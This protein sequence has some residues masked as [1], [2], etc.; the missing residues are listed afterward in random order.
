MGVAFS[1][2]VANR[3]L[4]DEIEMVES[5]ILPLMRVAID[6]G[7]GMLSRDVIELAIQDE[8]GIELQSQYGTSEIAL[9]S[10]Q[11]PGTPKPD[12]VLLDLR[13]PGMSGLES[14]TYFKEY[15]PQAKILV[16]TQ[17]DQESDVLQAIS[18]GASGYLLKSARVHE[19]VDGFRSVHAGGAS[20]DSSVTKFLIQIL[21][22]RLPKEKLK[23]E[24]SEREIQIL[25]LLSEGLVKKEIS[26]RLNISYSTVDTHVS[27]ISEKLQVNNAP[28][29]V[30]RAYKLDLSKIG[31]KI[32]ERPLCYSAMRGK[33]FRGLSFRY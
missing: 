5:I 28:S 14:I 16:L 20:L 25:S 6:I 3:R 4:V 11:D 7:P 21:Q 13:L 2:I 19:I 24:L 29:A 33:V 8:S 22:S 1:E 32:R 12:I 23:I 31:I 18:I 17:S 9:R 15:A 27:H 30:S 26:S 10:L